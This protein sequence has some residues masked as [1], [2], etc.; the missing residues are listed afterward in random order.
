VRIIP[1]LHDER[2]EYESN[3]DPDI[4]DELLPGA[5]IMSVDPAFRFEKLEPLTRFAPELKPDTPAAAEHPRINAA[6]S[7]A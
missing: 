7:A 2:P 3:I 6:A 4:E 1:L 5:S